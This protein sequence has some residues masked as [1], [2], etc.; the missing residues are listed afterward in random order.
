MRRKKPSAVRPN[1]LKPARPPTPPHSRKDLPPQLF[2]PWLTMTIRPSQ[3]VVLL[4]L[5]LVTAC[6]DPGVEGPTPGRPIFDGERALAL[7]ETQVGFGPRVPGMP[8][9]EAQAA[10]MIARLDS[11]AGEVVADSFVHTAADG[12]ELRLVN[13][14]GRFRPELTR[15]ILFLAH[16][17]TRPTSD[18]AS[19]SAQKLLP[20]PGANDGGSGTAVLLELAR[21]LSESPPPMGV[22]ILLVDG[23]DYGP[24]VDD[25][26]LG[27]I[28]YAQSLPEEG[29]PI[30]GL[31]LDMVGDADPLFPVE[32]NSAEFA[33]IV[34]RKVWR[35][36]ARLG[37]QDY[38]PEGVGARLTDDHIPLIQAGLPTAEIIDFSYGPGNAYWHTPEDNLAHVSAQTLEIVGEVMAELIYSGG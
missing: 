30:Y 33:S 21:L 3:L 23:E 15:R 26:F 10:W 37:Y 16:W 14:L 11:L 12:S 25:M 31:L 38:F 6:A 27:S 32:A 17:D 36:A 5:L 19:D 1:G 20:V 2:V 34:V 18:Q 22:D 7:V 28:R 4:L 8:G 9:H 24:G 13:V 35:A 29:R